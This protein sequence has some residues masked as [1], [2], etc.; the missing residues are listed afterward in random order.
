[1]TRNRRQPPPWPARRRGPVARRPQQRRCRAVHRARAGRTPR[2]AAGAVLRWS[3]GAR[4][5]HALPRERHPRPRHPAR[6]P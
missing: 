4:R 2:G 5:R 1:A 3:R 6:A